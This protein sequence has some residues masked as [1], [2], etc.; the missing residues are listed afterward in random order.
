M[1]NQVIQLKIITES[2]KGLLTKSSKFNSLYRIYRKLKSGWCGHDTVNDR[3]KNY[4]YVI[5]RQY[6]LT[7]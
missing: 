5:K 2:G 7:L 4:Q 6:S 3:N 1:T